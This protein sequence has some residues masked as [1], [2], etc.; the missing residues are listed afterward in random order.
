MVTSRDVA[1]VAGVSQATVSRVLSASPLVTDE[2]RLRVVAAMEKVGYTPNRSARAMRTG[3]T[4]TFGV[5]VSDLAN[6]FYP[7]LLEA[8]SRALDERDVRMTVWISDE[9]RNQAALDAIAERA[10]DGVIFTTVGE[11][12]TE[13]RAA[14]ERESPFVLVNR[15]LPMLSCDQVSSANDVGSA[16]ATRH[17][18]EQGCTRLAYLEGAASSTTATERLRGFQ[19]ALAEVDLKPVSVTGGSYSYESGRERALEL[20]NVDNPPDGLVCGN[21]IVAF[22]AL[23]AAR[24]RG[25]DVPRDVKVIGYDDVAMASWPAFSLST[26]RQDADLLA[27]FAV[28]ALM[29]R[30]ATPHM[31]PHRTI[32]QPALVR[33]GS[34]A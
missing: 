23:D 4:G 8:L 2:T 12:S 24:E 10:I 9:G 5:V 30:V 29:R 14:I 13:L 1:R 22:G 21:D 16:M 11:E 32:V 27:G 34:T 28:D 25:L 17:L 33:R 18:L 15:T 20:F 7:Q 26:I 3:R 6:P 19:S 31:A